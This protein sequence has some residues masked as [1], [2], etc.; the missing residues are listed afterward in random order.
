[1]ITP[2][3]RVSADFVTHWKTTALRNACGDAGVFSLLCLW[4]YAT[5]NRPDGCLAGLSDDDIE[6]IA[7]WSGP[8][9]LLVNTLIQL[10]FL[11]R[12]PN[13]TLIIHEWS[14][15]QPFIQKLY[16]ARARGTV[17][18][19]EHRRGMH[20][21]LK[22]TAPPG[23]PPPT[24][25]TSSTPPPD[26]D[27][28]PDPEPEPE[29]EPVPVPD[30]EPTPRPKENIRPQALSAK[31]GRPT[32]APSARSVAKD[33][34]KKET[35]GGG[36]A[37]KPRNKQQNARAC[38]RE[39]AALVLPPHQES[40]ANPSK[41]LDTATTTT[42]EKSFSHMAAPRPATP[43]ATRLPA[44]APTTSAPPRDAV[45]QP[46]TR[47]A[48][49]REQG[50][51]NPTP[52][53]QHAPHQNAPIAHAV[54]AL[55]HELLPDLPPVR[56]ISERLARSIA[57][58]TP[59]LVSA[60]AAPDPQSA[61]TAYFNEVAASDLLCGR[62]S[63]FTTTLPWL[64]DREHAERVVNGHYR[65]AGSVNLPGELPAIRLRDLQRR[66]N[67]EMQKILDYY[68]ASWEN[69]TMWPVTRPEQ[70]TQNVITLRVISACGGIEGI[71]SVVSPRNPQDGKAA[72]AAF[73]E[74]WVRQAALFEEAR[75]ALERDEPT[76]GDGG[77]SAP[78][79]AGGAPTVEAAPPTVDAEVT[80]PTEAT[81]ADENPAEAALD[82]LADAIHAAMRQEH[83]Q[84]LAEEH[85]KARFRV[86][87]GGAA[88]DS[89][90]EP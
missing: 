15:R 75:V 42:T 56:A 82:S 6:H 43:S 54:V 71:R 73:I 4:S 87:M 74:E 28:V 27:P 84:W 90:T 8:R 10:R 41:S 89:R 22:Y 1:M 60:Y 62:R 38:A 49:R 26:P 48:P 2:D 66:A 61:W 58:V 21:T 52:H 85:Q 50:A 7:R 11:D 83:Q 88:K 20:R 30:P 86:I 51:N 57:L 19:S 34:E 16:A 13:N 69:Q 32:E 77:A 72:R 29:P 36:M 24:P 3:F 59:F 65:T 31:V 45:P 68:N 67:L 78:Q 23:T 53:T 35:G 5:C 14:E 46:A 25:P 40:D 55:Y 33:R 80:S 79:A 18:K 64:A 81:K 39:A 76:R 12:D 47:A 70:L 9:G 17:C 63:H 37:T 44:P